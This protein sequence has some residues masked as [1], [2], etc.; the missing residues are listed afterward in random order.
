MFTHEN[1][2]SLKVASWTPSMV[3][4]SMHDAGIDLPSAG[5]FIEHSIN[6][7]SLCSMNQNDLKEMEIALFGTRTKIWRHIENLKSEASMD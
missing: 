5:R 1:F 6:E 4:Q 2:E 7:E 3:A